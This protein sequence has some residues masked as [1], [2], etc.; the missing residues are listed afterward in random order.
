MDAAGNRTTQW[1]PVYKPLN[2]WSRHLITYYVP[3][4]VK[5]LLQYPSLFHVLGD[6]PPLLLN[7]TRHRPRVVAV[8]P[9]APKDLLLL[10]TLWVASGPPNSTWAWL[11]FSPHR[12]CQ[13]SNAALYCVPTQSKGFMPRMLRAISLWQVSS[14]DL[15]C[16]YIII[17]NR[18][19]DNYTN[20]LV[21]NERM[22][23]TYF[24]SV[25]DFFQTFF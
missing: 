7:D 11:P 4:L 23:Y 3:L 9:R 6:L 2:H 20:Y 21:S 15:K 5:G 24:Y 14:F 25:K 16:L 13:L 10:P 12:L 1:K 8:R 22:S 19:P 17:I 18:V